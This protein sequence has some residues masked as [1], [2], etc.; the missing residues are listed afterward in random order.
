MAT[1]SNIAR[2]GAEARE[3]I[4]RKAVEV[5][6][7]DEYRGGS[8]QKVADQTG[9]TLPKL[10]HHFPSKK[11]LLRAL[12][13]HRDELLATKNAMEFPHLN[14]VEQFAFIARRNMKN[15]KMARLFIILA[16]ESTDPNHAAH[17]FFT[18]QYQRTE[19]TIHQAIVAQQSTKLLRDD[20]DVDTQMHT[21]L[22]ISDD[23]QLRW[24]LNPN[25]DLA[26]TMT[27]TLSHLQI[28]G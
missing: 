7:R 21:M 4:L 18:N 1:K 19:Q 25:F 15:P 6:D 3:R 20:L 23:L 17:E 24:L 2:K 12:L 16:T 5:F 13:Q 14:V 22:A 28:S 26:D 9:L 11:E 27:T 10:L 8:L